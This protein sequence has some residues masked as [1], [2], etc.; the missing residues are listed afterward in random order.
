MWGGHSDDG[1][2]QPPPVRTRPPPGV[3]WGDIGAPP[4]AALGYPAVRYCSAHDSPKHAAS[5]R[6]YDSPKAGTAPAQRGRSGTGSRPPAAPPGPGGIVKQAVTWGVRRP[7][8]PD[9]SWFAI[10]VALYYLGA[11]VYYMYVRIAFTLDFKDKWYSVVILIIE[12]LGVSAVLPYAAFNCVHTHP[13]GSYGLP[14]DD[15]L[16]EP[17]TKFSVRVLV[18]CYKEDLSVVAATIDAAMAADLPPGVTRHLYLCDDGKDPEKRAWLE[19]KYGSGGCVSY[20]TGRTRTKGEINGKSANLNHCLKTV[21]YRELAARPGDIPKEEVL[22]VFDADMQAKRNFFCKILEVMVDDSIA[23][24]LSPQA[25]SNVNPAVDIFNNTN[26]QFW[27]YIL[28]G[29][30]AMGYIACTGTNFCLRASALA[31]VGWFPDY[32]ITEDYALSM[33]LKA[34]GFKGRYLAEYLAVGEAPEELRNVL[35]QRSR[36]TKGHMQVFFSGRNPLVRWKLPLLHKWL[37]TNGTW[38]YFCT[39]ATTW[40]FLLVPFLSL[41]FDIQPVAFSRRFALAATLYL[42]ANFLVQNY[43]HVGDHMRGIWMANVSNVLLSFTYSKAIL[44]TL[45][46][47]VH[48]KKKAGFKPT[49]KTSAA[50]P[51]LQIQTAFMARITS[52]TRRFNQATLPQLYAPHASPAGPQKKEEDCIPDKLVMFVCLNL[53]IN[54]LVLALRQVY[55]LRTLTPSILFFTF[56]IGSTSTLQIVAFWMQIVSMLSGLGAVVA[57]WFI[58]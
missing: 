47:K 35:R 2:Q 53:C 32:C 45:L 36:W 25:F 33:E 20:V 56:V 11:V 4:A 22:V 7:T 48:I 13:T 51:S 28:P 55:V 23:L 34:A 44:N 43:F 46:A 3:G 42:S 41:M 18:P 57:L 9:A 12:F 27:E 6:L 26:Q 1:R 30:D 10:L 58:A 37:Y 38:S 19:E 39:V 14:P 17:D 31:A 8:R 52:L 49:D 24:C 21:I 5:P 15:G 40:T 29:C 50:N 16:T 54:T